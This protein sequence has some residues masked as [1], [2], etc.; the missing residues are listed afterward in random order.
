MIRCVCIGCSAVAEA[1]DDAAG[2]IVICARCGGVIQVPEAAPVGRSATGQPSARTRAS[3]AQAEDRRARYVLGGMYGLFAACLPFSL[4]HSQDGSP[5]CLVLF[6]VNLALGTAA[7]FLLL[8]GMHT[9]DYL[10]D[11]LHMP[12]TRLRALLFLL[13]LMVFGFTV[14]VH[15]YSP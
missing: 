15:T 4:W 11:W 13:P 6:G 5:V 8:A 10:T 9:P 1:H 2:T 12:F 7:G 14:A 3:A